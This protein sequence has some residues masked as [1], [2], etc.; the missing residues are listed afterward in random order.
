MSISEQNVIV[1]KFHNVVQRHLPDSMRAEGGPYLV[2]KKN[3][4]VLTWTW[5]V[6]RPEVLRAIRDLR[7]EDYFEPVSDAIP[8]PKLT[9]KRIA[10]GVK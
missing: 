3:E 8:T 1:R 6:N 10:D 4:C 2:Q 9:A 7:I 5:E